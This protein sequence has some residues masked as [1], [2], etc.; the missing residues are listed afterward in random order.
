LDTFDIRQDVDVMKKGWHQKQHKR[1]ST[2]GKQFTAGSKKVYYHVTKTR[3]VPNILKSGITR[4][5]KSRFRNV[6]LEVDSNKIYLVKTLADAWG[7][8]ETILEGGGDVHNK[9]LKVFAYPKYITRD[10]HFQSSGSLM[11]WWKYSGDIPTSDIIEVIDVDDERVVRDTRKAVE[12][13]N[14]R[15]RS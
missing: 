11:G 5:H 10:N 7:V 14:E 9:I 4:G 13:I 12:K 3:N 2:R 6:L 1:T 8:I 15:F